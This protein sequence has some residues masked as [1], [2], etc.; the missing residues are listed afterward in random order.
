V[1]NHESPQQLQSQQYSRYQRKVHSE[2][3]MSP[4]PAYIQDSR[5]V[6][7]R[8]P[9]QGSYTYTNQKHEVYSQGG[10]HYQTPQ[11]TYFGAPY[12][13]VYSAQY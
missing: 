4:S 3:A 8:Y 6:N 13:D 7:S 2:K 1:P 9:A 12:L 11:Q 5:Q 10:Q